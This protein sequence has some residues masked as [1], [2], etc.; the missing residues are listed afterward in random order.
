MMSGYRVPNKF[1]KT[2]LKYQKS[3][4]VDAPIILNTPIV[5]ECKLID[6]VRK[7]NF[8]TVLAEIV[9]ILADEKMMFQKLE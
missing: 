6:F 3:E 7:N 5:I 9:N 4:N 2:A 8:T 1:E